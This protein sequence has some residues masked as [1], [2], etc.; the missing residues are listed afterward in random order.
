[1]VEYALEGYT[2]FLGVA[3]VV[4]D[5]VDNELFFLRLKKTVGFVGEVDDDEAADKA[6][7]AGDCAFDDE[8]P[9]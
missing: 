9:W 2:V 4:V 3:A 7:T 5:S 1:M 6:D 8:D